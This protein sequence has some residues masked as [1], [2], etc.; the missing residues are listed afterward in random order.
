LRRELA[1]PLDHARRHGEAD[2]TALFAEVQN[3]ETRAA[4]LHTTLERERRERTEAHE[5]EQLQWEGERTALLTELHGAETQ[6][7]NVIAALERERRER[8]VAREEDER[9]WD[10]DRA[11][12]SA[13]LHAARAQAADVRASLERE[14]QERIDTHE[15]DRRRWENERGAL[16]TDLQAAERQTAETRAALDRERQERSDALGNERGRFEAVIAE[17]VETTNAQQTEY[18][19]LLAR[20]SA[21]EAEAQHLNEQY[22]AER[23][24]RQDA[25]DQARADWTTVRRALE[26]HLETADALCSAQRD[27]ARA[28]RTQS[29]ILT[30]LLDVDR[31]PTRGA[32]RQARNDNE[33]TT[34]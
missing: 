19:T 32:A 28:L 20:M 3:N 16:L 21:I 6:S 17:L 13:E 11:T 18:D 4:D 12:L 26:G 33:P 30:N 27:A 23:A 8:A 1:E 24:A 15:A 14:R 5:R 10:A 22:E 29:D 25:W 31:A 2:R 34:A 9:R 7:A